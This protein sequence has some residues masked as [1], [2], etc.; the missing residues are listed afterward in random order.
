MRRVRISERMTTGSKP[1]GALIS[2]S[3]MPRNLIPRG[4]ASQK[5]GLDWGQSK[6]M[7]RGDDEAGNGSLCEFIQKLRIRE[8]LIMFYNSSSEGRRLARGG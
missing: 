5:G 1:S 6:F 8:H 7:K 2:G 3:T 4:L